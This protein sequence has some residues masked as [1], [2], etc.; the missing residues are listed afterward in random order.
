VPAPTFNTVRA[1]PSAA[2]TRA[3][4]RGSV[5][6]VTVYVAPMV[7]YNCALDI[8]SALHKRGM[9]WM[10]GDYLVLR[11]GFGGVHE[12]AL[13]RGLRIR[14]V[15]CGS[16]VAPCSACQNAMTCHA[17]RHAR[18]GPSRPRRDGGGWAGVS[19]SAGSDIVTPDKA[20]PLRR[21]YVHRY[22]DC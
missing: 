12:H 19:L 4:I 14:H 21:R 9:R 6:R 16:L 17:P 5:R 13:P 11:A 2:Q 1:S 8:D 20:A 7:S 10:A 3:A 18:A 22:G 15:G